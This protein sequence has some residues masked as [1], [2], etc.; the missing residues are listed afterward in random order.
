[1]LPYHKYYNPYFLYL[2][3]SLQERKYIS[4]KRYRCK[5][6][7]FQRQYILISLRDRM[8][9]GRGHCAVYYISPQS[10]MIIDLKPLVDF[11]KF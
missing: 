5:E 7:L 2:S 4:I 1:M 8:Q 3:F 10:I 9:G 11:I 6:L